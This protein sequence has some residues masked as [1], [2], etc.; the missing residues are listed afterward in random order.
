MDS[1]FATGIFGTIVHAPVPVENS[2][3]KGLN[4]SYIVILYSNS[5]KHLSNKVLQLD[6]LVSIHGKTFALHQK[7]SHGFV[8]IKSCKLF[9]PQMHCRNYMVSYSTKLIIHCKHSSLVDCKFIRQCAIRVNALLYHQ[10]TSE[11]LYKC[12]S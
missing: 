2:V 1:L 4:C 11:L 3:A 6:H 12:K 10:E 8:Y 9:V 5:M 7:L